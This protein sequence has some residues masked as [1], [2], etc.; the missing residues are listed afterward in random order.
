MSKQR[1]VSVRPRRRR[2][3]K[4]TGN[5]HAGIPAA[6]PFACVRAIAPDFL[7]DLAA[8]GYPASTVSTY[9]RA[10]H[11]LAPDLGRV[12][13]AAALMRLL[14]KL[15]PSTRSGYLAAA[16]A[17][18]SWCVQSG[19]A[20]ALRLADRTR[21]R[22]TPPRPRP[23][24]AG[25]DARLSAAAA[26]PLERWRGDDERIPLLWLLLRLTAV[27]IGEALSLRWRG[28]S[29][30]RGREGV[31]VIGKGGK[32]RTIPL[33]HADCGKLIR[34]LKTA[35]DRARQP[36]WQGKPRRSLGEIADWPVFS[37]K[38]DVS[39]P[40]SYSAARRAWVK[41]CA[42][43]KLSA[44]AVLHQIRHTRGTEWLR[45]GLGEEY[46]MRL[47]GWTNRNMLRVYAE[48]TAEDLRREMRRLS[49]ES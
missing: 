15:S 42:R 39:R 14:E 31:T 24:D 38:Y 25:D 7:A 35:R 5:G 30:D 47:M 29:F 40:W 45:L 37:R 8:Q 12:D 6:A 49:A 46:V 22:R 23:L 36:D 2:P 33:L 4:A 19:R 27:R 17:F 32:L 48:I 44:G 18:D 26:K 21:V 20:R 43:S 1:T 11:R 34:A 9:G 13:S 41:L 16:R 3:R 10:L 28:V